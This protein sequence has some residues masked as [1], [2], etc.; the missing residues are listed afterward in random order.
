MADSSLPLRRP[1]PERITATEP[2]STPTQ[3]AF[4]QAIEAVEELRGQLHT[5]RATQAATRQAYWR[6]VGPL[7]AATVEA[8]RALYAPLENAL[9]DGYLSRAELQQ[10]TELLL[11]NARSLQERFGEDEATI[12][13]RYAPAPAPTEPPL[14]AEATDT[15]APPLLP[16]ERAAT[17]ARARRQQRAQAARAAKAQAVDTEDQALLQNTKAAYRQLAR[18][19]HPDR[20][21]QA[22]EPTQRAQTELMQRITAAYAA[23]DLATLLTLLA[24]APA[25]SSPTAETET[26]LQRYTQA[27][28]Q[29]QAQLA[30]ELTA[31]Q[32][33]DTTAPWSGTEKQQRTRLRQLKRDLRAELDYLG[34]L[35]PQ[36]A[37]PASLKALLRA[38]TSRDQ[39]T[40]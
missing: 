13:N 3:Q 25:T 31:A 2:T 37:D 26:L 28:A 9:L 30:K 40:L 8:R 15:N 11:Q 18:L 33:T 4:R 22:D 39:H 7:A 36:L 20:A 14:E 1:L 10:V 32:W 29:Q 35:L 16:H 27:L 34:Y 21:A 5:L 19:H 6:Q 17:A 23:N 12:I 24:D 38:L